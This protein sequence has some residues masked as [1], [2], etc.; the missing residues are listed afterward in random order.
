MCRYINS[1]TVNLIEWK[2][3]HEVF[4]TESSLISLEW[5]EKNILNI[6]IY[7]EKGGNTSSSLNVH[8]IRFFLIII[9]L[10]IY[11]KQGNNTI[12]HY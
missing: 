5:R 8:K 3:H 7:L 10:I 4:I 2:K 9:I 1:V 11:T 6:I 12:N